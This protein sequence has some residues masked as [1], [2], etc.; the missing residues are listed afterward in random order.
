MKSATI[1]LAAASVGMTICCLVWV[2]V[3][4]SQGEFS[5]GE[6]S[7]IEQGGESGKIAE[8]EA[9]ILKLE[10]EKAELFDQIEAYQE[11]NRQYG[12][13]V[14]I[15]LKTGLDSVKFGVREK[16]I[17]ANAARN[18]LNGYVH[19]SKRGME[20]ADSLADIT[21]P[22]WP[23]QGEFAENRMICATG[24]TY[25]DMLNAYIDYRTDAN[26]TNL[27]AVSE[28]MSKQVASHVSK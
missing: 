25:I 16:S 28:K 17:S 27:Q 26:W 8:L 18:Q 22:G 3:A 1:K 9:K 15:T 23:I 14:A 20:I 6:P 10:A 5:E 19:L 7:G 21:D 2:S 13:L 11:F 24:R 12:D 4:L